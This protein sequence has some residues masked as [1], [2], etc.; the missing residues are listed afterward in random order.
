M[1]RRTIFS[2]WSRCRGMRLRLDRL[3][4]P[5]LLRQVVLIESLPHQCFD[6]RLPADVEVLRGLVEFVQHGCRQVDVDSLDGM[7]HA[8]LPLEETRDVLP[9]IGETSDCFRG[10]WLSGLNSFLHINEPP[11]SSL[12]I[13]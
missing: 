1:A 4:P 8:A 3:R 13:M 7:N 11:P 5:G 2:P 12:S 6:D 10:Y 9:F